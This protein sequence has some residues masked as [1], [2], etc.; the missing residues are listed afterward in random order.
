MSRVHRRIVRVFSLAAL[1][2]DSVQNTLYETSNSTTASTKQA[3][4]SSD[5]V[6]NSELYNH[7]NHD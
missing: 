1:Y 2:S 5:H 4:N 3:D 7:G 6:N